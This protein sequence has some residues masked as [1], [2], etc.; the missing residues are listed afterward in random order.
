[1]NKIEYNC[2]MMFQELQMALDESIDAKNMVA[3]NGLN[4]QQLLVYENLIQNCK[5]DYERNSNDDKMAEKIKQYETEHAKLEEEIKLTDG[6][7]QLTTQ[8]IGEKNKKARSMANN[9]QMCDR[10]ELQKAIMFYFDIYVF[11]IKESKQFVLEHGTFQIK[12]C[13]K[14]TLH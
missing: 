11:Y 6:K 1:M 3:Q 13:Q 8:D 12:P 9:I 10:N 14:Y 4:K 7:I 5:E 2:N